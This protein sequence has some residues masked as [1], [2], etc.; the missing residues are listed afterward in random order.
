MIEEDGEIIQYSGRGVAGTLAAMLQKSG[1]EV[2][3]PEHQHE[4]GWDFHV[5]TQGRRVWIQISDLGYAF[6]LSSKCYAG[7]I[8]RRGDEDVYAEVLTRLNT[9]LASDGRFNNVQWKLRRDVLSG[10]AGTKDPVIE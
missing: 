8:P 2:S 7:L 1:Y 5:R 10:A 9:G 3:P 6:V 4:N